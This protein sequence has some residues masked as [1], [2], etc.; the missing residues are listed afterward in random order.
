MHTTPAFITVRR[1]I[2]VT[3]WWRATW[4]AISTIW[5]WP[6]VMITIVAIRTTLFSKIWEMK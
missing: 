4:I 5:R 2:H 3:M 6:I 1:I